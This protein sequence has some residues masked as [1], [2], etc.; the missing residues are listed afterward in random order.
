MYAMRRLAAW[1]AA[2]ARIGTAVLDGVAGRNLLHCPAHGC[3]RPAS[4]S[5]RPWPGDQGQAAGDQVVAGVDAP[6]LTAL[7]ER[8]RLRAAARAGGA[9][10]LR[11]HIVCDGRGMTRCPHPG[12][13]QCPVTTEA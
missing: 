2:G 12:G 6:E 13:S 8:A 11:G 5:C 4:R 3:S 1:T 7:Q 9:D 10:R